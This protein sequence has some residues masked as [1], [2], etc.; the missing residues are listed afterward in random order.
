M[1]ENSL[2]ESQ[3]S[4]I[5]SGKRWTALAS[6][7]LQCAVAA[8]LIVLPLLHP[9]RLVSSINALP[10]SVPPPSKPPIH[11]EHVQQTAASS[12]TNTAIPTTSRPLLPSIHPTSDPTTEAPPTT[13][14]IGQG[15]TSDIPAALS[16]GSDTHSTRISI[17]QPHASSGPLHISKGVY[18]GMLLA[19]IQIGRA[20]CRERVLMPV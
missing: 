13:T 18:A 5:S 2:V 11:V 3:L 12:S 19:P 14:L 16:T 8:T 6:I 9:E 10:V 15:M 1:F 17:A 4:H 7:T 20:S